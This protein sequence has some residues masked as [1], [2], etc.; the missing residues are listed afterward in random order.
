MPG[1]KPPSREAYQVRA[2]QQLQPAVPPKPTLVIETT[3][4]DTG[5]RTQMFGFTARHVITT[6]KQIPLVET[7]QIPQETVTDGWYI[8]LDVLAAC[9]RA[10][11]GAFGV[12]IAGTSK[13][14]EPPQI[15]VPTFK[16][17]GNPERGFAL[18]TKE[19]HRAI[20]SS[21]DGQ[22][23]TIES[24]SNETQVTELS[25]EPLDSALFEVPGSFSKVSQIRRSPV[26]SSWTRSLGWLDYYWARLKRAI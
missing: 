5:E 14:G 10:S 25:T 23:R 4:K 16:S 8:D 13:I 7:G 21:P 19:L 24:P 18:A 12:V 1:P 17:I 15:P 9:D 22:V 20:I 2:E 3:T 26:V 11:S 6:R